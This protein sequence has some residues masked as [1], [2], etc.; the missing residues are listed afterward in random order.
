MPDAQDSVVL[1]PTREQDLEF[2]IGIERPQAEA[3]LVTAWP[4]ERHLHELAEPRARHLLVETRSD[5]SP[6]GFV[7]LR[8][9]EFDA[10]NIELVRIVIGPKGRGY[11]RRALRLA[12]DQAFQKMGARR[13]WLDVVE[14]NL[15]ARKLYRSE[16]F[17]EEGALRKAARAGDEYQSLMLMS[18]LASDREA[19]EANR[20]LH[21]D[22]RVFAPVSN[23]S[24]GE[25]SPE[26]IFHYRQDGDLVWAT[27]GGG[28]IRFGTLVGKA[29][30]SGNLD[31]RYQH[32]NSD[33]ELMTGVCRSTPETLANGRLRLHERW[34][35]TSGDR[36][37]G[38][39]VIEELRP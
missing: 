6:V 29:D 28:R 5:G 10:E 2:V 39:S 34:R 38:R 20:D 33:G 26:T 31:F 13:L 27:Y 4:R 8:A 21:Y 19:R 17:V 1:R 22:G 30:A 9:A 37:E 24:S 23:S 11:G 32:L 35:W 16:G 25:A 15:R 18:M 36:S 12:R 3:G 7:I 14:S